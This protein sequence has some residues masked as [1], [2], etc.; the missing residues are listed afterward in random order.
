MNIGIVTTWFDRGAAFVSKQFA[1]VLSNDNKVYIFAR[2]GESYDQSSSYWK[3]Y[4]VT[5]SK[6]YAGGSTRINWPQFKDWVE[7]NNIDV[8]LFNEQ[9][10]WEIVADAK[11]LNITKK[12]RP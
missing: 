2:G 3:Q 4:P 8:V 5:W 12:N 9:Q 11:N 10:D 7:D 6:R 1:D